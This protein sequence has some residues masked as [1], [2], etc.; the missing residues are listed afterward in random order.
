MRI[1][2]TVSGA[3]RGA[4]DVDLPVLNQLVAGGH[5]RGGDETSAAVLVNHQIAGGTLGFSLEGGYE[6]KWLSGADQLLKA[7]ACIQCKRNIIAVL[8][9]AVLCFALRS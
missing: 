6:A 2:V 5:V 3:R 9:C 8:C 4:A 1:G 7:L